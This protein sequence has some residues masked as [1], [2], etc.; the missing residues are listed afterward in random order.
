M[1]SLVYIGMGQ[2]TDLIISEYAEGSS[3][4][5]YIEIY[6][7]TG[8]TVDLSNYEVWIIS[9]GGSWAEDTQELSGN[10]A[11][12]EVYVIAHSSSV[13]TIKD[14][15]DLLD[16]ICNWNGDDAVGLA[17]DI[18]GTMTLIDAIGEDG[19]D[20]DTGWDMAGTSNATKDH[21]LV[22]K[23][24]ICSPQ[25]NWATSAGTGVDDSEW[26]VYASDTWTYLGSHT[27]NCAGGV[28]NPTDFTVSSTLTE[29]I[30]LT[31]TNAAESDGVWVVA[32]EAAAVDVVISDGEG[33]YN[34]IDLSST[35]NF[36]TATDL[37]DDEGY[38]GTSGNILV[39][40]G[41]GSNCSV[42]GLSENT[43]YYFTIYNE[44]GDA[45]WSSGTSTNGTT[46]KSEPS[47]HVAGFTAD[48]K[49]HNS[50]T[51][52]W[53]ASVGGADG[54]VVTA[55]GN[56]PV[57]GA[58]ETS[59]NG[60][61]VVS[62]TTATVD[63]LEAETAYTFLIY[64]YNN[65]GTNIDYKTDGTV[66]SVTE[67]TDAAPVIVAPTA[68][69][70]FISEVSDAASEY[71]SE[72]IE[73]YNNSNNVIDLSNSKLIRYPSAGGAAEL[74]FD[75]N[76]EGSGDTQIPA[77]GIIVIAR[78]ATKTEFEAEWGAF[79]ASENYNEGSGSLYF[80]TGRQ[81]A[82]KD[83]GT[84]NTDD[85]TEIDAT[86][87]S[88][89]NGKR[90]YQYPAKT[91]NSDVV[92]N[93][94]PGTIESN[95][96]PA[97]F[98]WDGGAS[99]VFWNDAINWS[100]D[101]IPLSSTN[102][103]IPA[104]KASVE[105]AADATAECNNLTIEGSLTIKSDATGTGSLII[106]GTAT[107]NITAERYI[108]GHG[109]DGNSG[110]REIASPV[111]TFDIS[112][113]TFDPGV[114]DDFY[115]WDELAYT[116]KN[117][118]QGNP[119]QV[120]PGN[121]YLVAYETTATKTFVGTPN[122]AD[123][124]VDLT[125]TADQGEGWNLIGNP[126]PSGLTWYTDWPDV[127]NVQATAKVYNENSDTYDDAD[128]GTVIPS[129]QGFFVEASS[130]VNEFTIPASKRI[131]SNST[132]SKGFNAAMEHFKLKVYEVE[133]TIARDILT[134]SLNENSN[135]SYDRYD[136]KEFYGLGKTPQLFSI[137]SENGT[138][139]THSVNPSSIE[140]SR[141]FTLG[142]QAVIEGTYAVAIE[143][144][145]FGSD[146]EVSLED[147]VTGEMIAIEEVASY[148]FTATPEDAEHRF[149]LHINKST[150]GVEE[151]M[152]L[153]GVNVYA[154]SN[155]IYINSS[156]ELTNA[157]AVVYNT[158]GQVITTQAVNTGN[159]T[160]EL[161]AQGAYIV[162]LQAEEGVMT[163]KVIIK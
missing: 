36:S 23:S 105:I 157:T 7:G 121:G 58:V 98:T 117:Y 118:H 6:N 139:S 99:T 20:P 111:A 27:S 49:T 75:F 112:G 70:V 123:V 141:V 132:I 56:V 115:G 97:T 15:A 65:S 43:Q 35:G 93:S 90:D 21:T 103:T 45:A 95:E 163:Q 2:T 59:D 14:K 53:T 62:G 127:A 31:W 145:T 102:V 4:N 137:D 52:S 17:K 86:N 87:Q 30:N 130:A 51:L 151:G 161:V 126:F 125:K 113:S 91:W 82:L 143:E 158:L 67:T 120:I 10:L 94:N 138:L 104:D 146:Y 26:I 72:F 131:H 13:Q 68:G 8:S 18:A 85:G 48:S 106:N 9:N 3:Y 73:L 77:Y 19:V 155:Q 80:G 140:E 119:S 162:K 152:E 74:T 109:N 61:Q 83:G 78:G 84:A 33:V 22:R 100:S 124:D 122:Y 50:V 96:N 42:T 46:I 153:E 24:T 63:G 154:Y 5:K 160:I 38:S 11:Y 47:N 107:G 34:H 66:P 148:E 147:M 149:N 55:N 29:Q 128:A 69:V 25:T 81:W 1:I 135:E 116:W 57:D 136:S 92:G 108:A 129:H 28:S 54:Y 88:V 134:I 71:N 76:A 89:A 32:R 79:P 41:N 12:G 142:V 159:E 39:Y 40:V 156:V 44:F 144:N 110:W 64:P 16:G 133:N 114:N 37:V 101:E 150:F 60:Q